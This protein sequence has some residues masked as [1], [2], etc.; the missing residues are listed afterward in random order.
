MERKYLTVT[1][2]NRYLKYK[3]DHD[4][5]LQRILL[6]AEISNFKHHSRGHLYLTLKDDNSQIQAVMF[7]S[8]TKSLNFK[9]KDGDQVIVEGHIA[10][11]EPYGTYQVYIKK[12]DK[13]GVGDLYLAYEM[14][15]EKLEKLG[16]FSESHKVPLPKYP[17]SIGVI[18]SPTGAA[19]RDIINV[20]SIRYPLARIIVYPALVQGVNAKE[21]ISEQINQA[22]RDKLVDVLIVGRGGGSIEDLWAFNEE[23]V[24]RSIY[25]SKIP[26]ISAVGHETDF[27]IADF[28]SDRRASTPSH[29]AEIC[30]PNKVELMDN[31]ND[32][33]I[34][35]ANSLNN[36]YELA[37][38]NFSKVVKSN[39]IV[40]PEK[41]LETRKLKLIYLED[42]LV[43]YKPAKQIEYYHNSIK[44]YRIRLSQII[45]NLL[46]ENQH[47]F[48]NQIDKL[49]L[50]NPLSI[51]KKG[52]TITKQDNQ[53]KKSIKEI[54]ESKAITVD[55]HDGSLDC[56]INKKVVK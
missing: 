26:I 28:V 41:I 19:I 38:G 51:M 54:D 32:S 46:K 8:N 45:T 11:Y 23:I 36:A 30:V 55:F 27:T 14:L 6:K 25:A 17:K 20:I 43:A 5:N 1:A 33:I 15:K 48:N 22:N 47:R 52:Y 2:L 21:S 29:A 53:I 35:L 9:P 7:A 31:I 13:D 50:V 24:A 3:F 12:M 42:K 4:E 44:N 37:K 39:V 34:R 10:V 18:T 40:N 16:L 56:K 49:E